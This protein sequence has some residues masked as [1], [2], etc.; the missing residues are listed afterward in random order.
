MTRDAFINAIVVASA[1]GASTNCPPHLIAIARHMGIELSLDDW[2]QHGEQVPLIVNCMPAGEYLG[3]SFHRSGGVPAVM[4]QLDD[5]KM[6][7]RDCR[8][9]SGR[10]VGEIADEAPAADNDVIRT[11][12][13]PMKHGAGFMVLSGNFFDSAIM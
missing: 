7:R 8:S 1:L 3:E 5:A 6:L 2:Q 4:R 13:D 10:T 12:A 9:V 11:A